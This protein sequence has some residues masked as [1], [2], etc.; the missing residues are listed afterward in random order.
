MQIIGGVFHEE[1]NAKKRAKIRHKAEARP[2]GGGCQNPVCLC[3]SFHFPSVFLLIN[4]N[5]VLL[6]RCTDSKRCKNRQFQKNRKKDGRF[7]A[8]PGDFFRI[9]TGNGYLM[10]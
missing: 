5:V 10:C 3:V 2:G 4:Y 7:F 8:N 6:F 1:I 9:Q